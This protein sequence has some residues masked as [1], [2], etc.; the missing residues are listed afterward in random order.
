MLIMK[1]KEIGLLF[2][3]TSAFTFLGAFDLPVGYYF[4]LR[5]L[6]F[7]AGFIGM[8]VFKNDSILK[9]LF[10]FVIILF[11]PVFQVYLYSKVAW[12]I[13]DVMIGGLFL[14]RGLKLYKELQRVAK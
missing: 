14:E 9:V 6:V 10:A 13:I 8:I 11:N 1:Q 2:F 5:V 12:I 4:F 7:V 3:I